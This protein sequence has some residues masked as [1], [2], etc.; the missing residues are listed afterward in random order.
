MNTTLYRIAGALMVSLTLMACGDEASSSPAASGGAP[1]ALVEVAEARAGEL[2]DSW[3]TLG[4]VVAL[5]QAELAPGASGPM[6]KVLVREGDAVK[7]GELLA[8]LDTDLALARLRAAEA[9][10]AEAAEAQ[11]QAER[12]LARAEKVADGV[13]APLELEQLRSQVTQSTARHQSQSAAVAL[14]RAE[15]GRHRLR[16]PFDGRV[17]ARSVD[18]GDWVNAGQIS[19]AMV[20][21]EDLE[22]RVEVSQELLRKL[23]TGA[24]AELEGALPQ[25]AEVVALVP[26][27][28]PTS[29]TA[30]VRLRPT[31]AGLMPGESVSV[32]FP[33]T[34]GGEGLLV[35]RDALVLGPDSARLVRVVDGA[36]ESLPVEVL[37]RGESEALVRGEGLQAGDVLVTRGNERL[38]PGQAVSIRGA[39]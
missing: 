20:S 17:T 24:A 27:L 6:A 1:P 8:E 35:P 7:R 16:A 32:R 10:E 19:L 9:A 5:D 11:A 2:S 36:A 31:Q 33:V 29:R 30:L 25:E 28:D 12:A 26:A 21:T 4:D 34:W 38:R 13:I 3:T 37:A 39:E 23:E 14:A 22:V 18:P 15:L